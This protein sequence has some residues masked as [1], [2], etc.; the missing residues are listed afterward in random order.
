MQLL[1]KGT[2]TPGCVWEKPCF[3]LISTVIV[4][5][6][7]AGIRFGIRVASGISSAL[8]KRTVFAVRPL[9][10]AKTLIVGGYLDVSHSSSQV[11]IFR[12]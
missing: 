10:S 8:M 5:P 1:Q 11:S 4:G 9:S 12:L 6:Y 3:G 2:S 7:M